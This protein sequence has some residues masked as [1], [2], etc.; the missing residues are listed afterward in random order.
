[1]NSGATYDDALRAIRSRIET[2]T[3]ALAEWS[4]RDDSKPQPD[5]RQAAND[6]MD[7][8]DAAIRELYGLRT[9]LAGEI[10]ASDDA[11]AARAEALLRK[12]RSER[13]AGK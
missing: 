6:A 2:L 12:I 1:M 7:D 11:T 13:E 10:R 5:I 3:G 4:A 9:R 8:I